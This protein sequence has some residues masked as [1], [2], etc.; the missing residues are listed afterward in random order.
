MKKASP[1]KRKEKSPQKDKSG[2]NTDS[3]GLLCNILN[4]LRDAGAVSEETGLDSEAMLPA[5]SIFDDAVPEDIQAKITQLV[6]SNHIAM[7]EDNKKSVKYWILDKGLSAL[8]GIDKS[9]T[10]NNGTDKSDSNN[11]VY[12]NTTH[13]TE[14]EKDGLKTIDLHTPQ[15]SRSSV[16]AFSPKR[17]YEN[18]DE[19][20][21]PQAKKKVKNA[22]GD[23]LEDP[24][25]KD[26]FHSI[27]LVLY[28]AESFSGKTGLKTWD[29]YYRINYLLDFNVFNCKARLAEEAVIYANLCTFYIT[30]D[31]VE[32]EDSERP[33]Y[34]TPDGT[35]YI[36]GFLEEHPENKKLLDKIAFLV[37][38]EYKVSVEKRR[39]AEEHARKAKEKS[40][41]DMQSLVLLPSSQQKSPESVAVTLMALLERDDG[42]GKALPSANDFMTF[43]NSSGM[44]EDEYRK[45]MR[46]ATDKLFREKYGNLGVNELFSLGQIDGDDSNSNGMIKIVGLKLLID[47]NNDRN[48]NEALI[49]IFK[50][51]EIATEVT[52]LPAGSFLWVGV[53]VSGKEYMLN[54]AIEVVTLAEYCALLKDK[55]ALSKRL[56]SATR[57]ENLT[58][59]VEGDGTIPSNTDDVVFFKL[60]KSLNDFCEN[61]RFNLIRTLSMD[62]TIVS[63]FSLADQILREIRESRG[64]KLVLWPGISFRTLGAFV[65]GGCAHMKRS[66]GVYSQGAVDK[67]SFESLNPSFFD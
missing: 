54:T 20:I 58:F 64:N 44:P 25:S 11:V 21:S 4:I 27:L 59:I 17:R 62:E 45:E 16:S 18:L 67:F 28:Q 35:A 55:L 31:N 57:I 33:F 10:K 38:R 7:A 49:S 22:Y 8:G 34:L 48:L 39:R 53:D 40:V 12:S 26:A 30:Y 60:H 24:R 37:Q 47:E 2:S 56:L 6:K 19:I 41:K 36:E 3:D 29:I 13:N 32:G 46:K 43:K 1:A 23:V 14:P 9:E 51:N 50:S 65:Q 52:E 63:L 61:G 66:T 42:T 15:K 5:L